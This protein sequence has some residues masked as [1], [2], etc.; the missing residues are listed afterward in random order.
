MRFASMISCGFSERSCSRRRLALTAVAGWLAVAAVP[1]H[2]FAAETADPTPMTTTMIIVRLDTD[3]PL[4][5]R[6]SFRDQPPTIS[7][8][9][10]DRQVVAALPE[11]FTMGQG[12]IRS[13]A[14]SYDAGVDPAAL[15]KRYIRALHIGVT[16]PYAYRVRSEPRRLMIEIDHPA[17]VSSA[18]MEVGLRGGT[19]I[20]GV[21][22]IGV[23]E[24]FRA[25]QRALASVAPTPPQPTLGREAQPLPGAS[26]SSKTAG[27]PGGQRRIAPAAGA[28]AGSSR[29]LRSP[30]TPVRAA[31]W[32]FSRVTTLLMLALAATAALR[33][34][35]RKGTLARVLGRPAAGSSSAQ[36]P[37]GVALV[38][39][40]VWRAF[41]RQGYEL[42]SE[43]EL[44]AQAGTLRLM[45]KDDSK[46]ALLVLGQGRFFEKRAVERF[47]RAMDEVKAEQGFLVASGSFTVPAQRIAKARRVTLIGREQLAELLSVGAGREYVAQQLEQSHARLEEAKDTLRQHAAELD[48]L[49]KQRNEASWYLGEERARS[50]QLETQMEEM[51]RLVRW[52]AGELQRWEQEATARRKQWDESQWY[53]GESQQRVSYLEAQLGSLQEIVT[54]VDSAERDRDAAQWYLGEER[55]KLD[56]VSRQLADLQAQREA[57]SGRERE[58]QHT[59]ANLK[60]E[61]A[62]SPVRG[63]RR[64]HARVEIPL[65]LVE[66]LN[67]GEQPL[68]S[69]APLEMS[70][71]GF[72]VETDR[73]LPQRTSIRI[74]L[75]FPGQE[76][77]ESQGRVIWQRTEQPIEGG[78]SRYRSGI[79]LIDVSAPACELIERLVSE[80]RSSHS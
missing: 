3:A 7:I 55:A 14:T 49:R 34:L 47:I 30:F 26:A 33:W 73:E 31:G 43:T 45:A 39:Q 50:A 64:H 27:I 48:A 76:P 42:V 71:A 20:G 9:F 15:H 40:L 54:R 68:F 60:A 17:S 46:T 10:P 62:G 57:S 53:L 70:R 8:W 61:I 19:M 77:I 79:W 24:R 29:S 63:D 59:L 2:G 41:E 51:S 67:G 12:V 80:S 22:A 28:P 13:M 72:G 5:I 44:S 69:G 78:P 66:L 25:M 6:T 58:L 32:P 18:A 21:G 36:R 56:A 1:F 4:P 23:S 37:S 38:E 74:R 52:H 75:K 65:A 11:R 35:S 16:G